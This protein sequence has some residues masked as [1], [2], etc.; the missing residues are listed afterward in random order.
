MGACDNAICCYGREVRRITRWSA[1]PRE[2]R[3][4]IA[5]TLKRG[6]LYLN[7]RLAFSMK[8]VNINATKEINDATQITTS[9]DVLGL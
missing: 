1:D 3:P 8:C 5:R 9:R 6:P 4:K 7:V 2:P